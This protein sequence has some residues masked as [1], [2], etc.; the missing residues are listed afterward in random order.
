MSLD[1]AI[2]IKLPDSDSEY[3]LLPCKSGMGVVE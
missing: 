1:D 2:E 3:Q